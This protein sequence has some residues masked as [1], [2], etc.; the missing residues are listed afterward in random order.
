MFRG[1]SVKNQYKF[2][3]ATTTSLLLL[4]SRTLSIVAVDVAAAK[5]GHLD[6]NARLPV[7]TLESV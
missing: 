7:L 5:R 1:I 2:S 6:P 3:N 4:P